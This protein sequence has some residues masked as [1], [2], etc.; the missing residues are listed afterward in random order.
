MKCVFSLVDNEPIE[1]RSPVLAAKGSGHDPFRALFGV[2]ATVAAAGLLA[3]SGFAQTSA[4][5]D[6]FVPQ[7][8]Q[9]GKDVIW[10]PTPESLVERMLAM[11]KVT[12]KDFVIDL[13][14]GDGRTVIAAA[15]KGATALGIEYN[16]NMVALSQRNAAQAGVSDRAKFMKADIFETDFSKA[17]VITMYL[18]PDLNIRLRPKLL[19]MRA[20]TRVVSHAFTMGDWDPDERAEVESRSA[21]LWIVPAKVQ[22]EWMFKGPEQG[23]DA[24]FDQKYQHVSGTI[25]QG[26]SDVKIDDGKLD[27]DAI[28]F[29]YTDGAKRY[30]FTGRVVGDEIRGGLDG[31]AGNW[32]GSRKH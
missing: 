26:R 14:S 2:V 25:K 11:A 17:T 20:G 32:V 21:M 4:K 16:P 19:D 15:K 18:L 6:E 28:A 12:A 29:N 9:A 22:G 13:G 24:N 5:Q 10:V 3:N 30:R 8:G 31:S 7:V 23:F 27:G 1:P